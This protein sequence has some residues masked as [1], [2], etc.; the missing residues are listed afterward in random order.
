[1]A[2]KTS[3]SPSAQRSARRLWQAP[4]A[5]TRWLW[6]TLSA[7]LSGIIF[8]WYLHALST[9]RFPGA[10]TDPLRSFG[11]V[12]FV[13]VLL[14]ASYSLRRRFMRG[15][16]GMARD[17]LQMHI[18]LSIAALVIALLHEN[19]AFL[20]NCTNLHCITQYEGGTS[21]LFALIVLV[22]SGILGRC[23]DIWEA[24]V[25]ANEASTNGVGIV[26]ALEEH[27]QELEYSVERLS[28]GK[29][30]A[31]KSYCLAALNQARLPALLP[32]LSPQERPDFQQA[33]MTLSN[34]A[35]LTRSLRRQQL[36]KRI[37]QS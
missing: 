6:L 31:F 12:A 16:P 20:S 33:R 21:A 29:S 26:Q 1:M 5:P 25:I 9:E 37:M 15:L 32:A 13:L 14:A 30:D 8:I 36:A 4:H 34:Y 3:P 17:W 10:F 23:L 11:I 7:M 27:L 22:L 35:K 24:R 18:W 2:T 28:A 19:F